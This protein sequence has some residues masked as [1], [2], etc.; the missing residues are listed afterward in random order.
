MADAGVQAE[1]I[2]HTLEALAE[3]DLVLA[4]ARYAESMLAT[5]PELIPVPKSPPE[6]EDDNVHPSTV[7]RL[8]GARHPMIP[9][10]SVV[11][12]NIDIADDTHVLVITGPNTGGKTVTLKTAGLLTLMALAGLHIPVDEGSQLSCFDRVV[13]DIGDEQSIEQSLSTFSSHLTN[14]LS[15]LEDVD[16]RSLVL[17]DE[18]GAG[19]DPAEGSALARALLEALRRRRSTVFVATHYPELKLYAH[20]TPGVR[21]RPA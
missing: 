2:A 13:A 10:E 18:L 11:P 5:A 15:F 8:R 7:V 12:V 3:L 21:N 19:T 4:K 6:P 9:P 16:H 17:V 1:E 14:I 20:N